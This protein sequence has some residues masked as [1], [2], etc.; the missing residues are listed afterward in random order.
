ML[1][2]SIQGSAG[3][4]NCTPMEARLG[5]HTSMSEVQLPVPAIVSLVQ[6]KGEQLAA[7]EAW[8]TPAPSQICPATE[9]P[10]QMALP[11]V[12]PR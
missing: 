10:V 2:P 4:E 6:P 8:H 11:Q 7:P 9:S 5:R 12:V 1:F 3:M